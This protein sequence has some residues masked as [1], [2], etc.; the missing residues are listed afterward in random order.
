MSALASEQFEAP[1]AAESTKIEIPARPQRLGLAWRLLALTIGGV[2]LALATVYVLRLTASRENWLHDRLLAAETAATVFGASPQPPISAALASKI[3]DA[4]GVKRIILTAPDSRLTISDPKAP[5]SSDFTFDDTDPSFLESVR[6]AFDALFAPRG[7]ILEVVGA[8]SRPGVSVEILIDQ[9]PSIDDLWQLTR[10]YFV[11]AALVSSVVTL[12]LWA[13]LWRLVIYPVQRLTTSI[14]AFGENPQDRGRIVKPSGRNDEI[15]RAEAALA[16]MQKTLA[17]EL[18]QSKRLAELGMT[19]ARINHDL[20]NMLAAAQLISD[21]FA[22]IPDPLAQRLAPQLVATLDRAI[23]FCKST[24]AYGCA[25]ERA[26]QRQRFDLRDLAR[27]IVEAAEATGSCEVD[28]V[29]DIPPGFE[30]HAD[31]DHVRRALENLSRN[32]REALNAQGERR[33]RPAAIRFAAT[34]APSGEALIEVSDSGPGI[35]TA[36]SAHMFEPFQRSTRD[37]GSGLGLAIA[38]DLAQRNGGSIRLVPAAPDDVYCGARFVISLPA[39]DGADLS[40]RSPS[41]A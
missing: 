33:E 26:P 3:V 37:G 13:A 28:Y 18:G 25:R 40:P 31:P 10:N 11:L 9:T 16:E 39:P 6:G 21:R 34:H 17:R 7:S 14:I 12:A 29:I 5:I 20:R 4:I 27:E 30:L 8:G 15:G 1:V 32:A 24:L 36:Q 2:L 35:P 22:T 38:S 41:G 23:G 19:V